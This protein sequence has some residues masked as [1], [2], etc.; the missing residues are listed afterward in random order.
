MNKIAMVI[1]LCFVGVGSAY[2]YDDGDFQIWNTDVEEI[3]VSKDMKVALEE[4]FR[5][6]DNAN[7]FYYH[8]YDGGVFYNLNEFINV[9]G[10]Y[11]HIYSKSKGKFKVEN[12]PYLTATF[13]YP[14]AGFKFDSRNRLEYQHFDYQ[15]DTWRYRNKFTVKL[16]FTFTRLRLQPFVSDEI[17]VRL[18]GMKV[19]NQ[20]RFSSGI[21]INLLKNLKSEI[22][23]MLVSQKSNGG[24]ADTNVLGIKLK[25]AF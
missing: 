6:A 17:L 23:Y 10:G 22:Y 8:H 14:I 12:A 15:M 1:C 21:S 19:L 5:W 11:R 18:G 20:N 4:E 3:N 24:W 16:P 2:A 9:G 7:D 25:Y 13:S